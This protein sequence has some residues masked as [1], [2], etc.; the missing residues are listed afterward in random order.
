[1][2]FKICKAAEK[3]TEN[4]VCVYVWEKDGQVRQVRKDRKKETQIEAERVRMNKCELFNVTASPHPGLF[5][6]SSPSLRSFIQVL[7]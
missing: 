7:F 3:G 6:A 5:L 4:S 1:M 2:L